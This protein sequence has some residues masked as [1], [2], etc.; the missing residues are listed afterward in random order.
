MVSLRRQGID[1]L[2]EQMIVVVM[3]PGAKFAAYSTKLSKSA[4]Q[5]KGRKVTTE[6]REEVNA[7]DKAQA[8]V[9]ISRNHGI[10]EGQTREFHRE[11]S[12]SFARSSSGQ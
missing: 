6:H 11:R 12:Q 4:S 8:V 3:S 5:V 1:Y 2:S 7:R 9:V 10:M